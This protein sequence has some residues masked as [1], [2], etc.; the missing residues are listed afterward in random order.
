MYSGGYR[1]TGKSRS[2]L[3]AGR[4]IIL[5][6]DLL[7]KGLL[8]IYKKKSVETYLEN[9]MKLIEGEVQKELYG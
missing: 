3:T 4:K 9:D 7:L 5:D 6:D 2:F 8:A 1:W